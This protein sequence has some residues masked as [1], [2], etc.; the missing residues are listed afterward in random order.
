MKM[1]IFRQLIQ[2]LLFFC[3]P[4]ILSLDAQTALISDGELHTVNFNVNDKV[5]EFKIPDDLTSGRVYFEAYGGDGGRKKN[6]ADGN[7]VRAKGGQGAKI[8]AWFEIGTEAGE[9]PPGATVLFI[10]GEHGQNLNGVFARG[11]GGGG[12]TGV[13]FQE[14]NNA[15]TLLL[16]SGGGMGG[17]ADCC[18]ASKDGRP[19]EPYGCVIY[20]D[21]AY[22][23][24]SYCHY[25]QELS[26]ISLCLSGGSVL[27]DNSN[28]YGPNVV[29]TEPG[30]YVGCASCK[31]GKRG[32][33]GATSIPTNW[34]KPTGGEGGEDCDNPSLTTR[35]GFGFGGGAAGT[36]GTFY[37]SCG[38]GGGF[39]GHTDK[40]GGSYINDGIALSSFGKVRVKRGTTSD[41]KDGKVLYRI[42]PAAEAICNDVTV[43]ISGTNSV[44]VPAESLASGVLDPEFTEPL[45]FFI[46]GGY[47][48]GSS[49]LA[50]CSNLGPNLVTVTV[51]GRYSGNSTQCTSIVTVVDVTPP[52]ANCNDLTITLDNNGDYTLSNADINAISA[53]STD[54]CGIAKREV[55]PVGF[56]CFNTGPQTVILTLTDHSGTTNTCIANVNV[57]GGAPLSVN[58]QNTTVELDANGTVRLSA[59]A[60]HAGSYSDC[61][62]S[63][64]LSQSNFTCANIGD[65]TV[66]LTGTD[67][68]GVV[69]SCQARV[70]VED[71]LAP[72]ITCN[73]ETIVL[74][75]QSQIQV[76]AASLVNNASDNCGAQYRFDSRTITLELQSDIYASD[77]SWT[78]TNDQTNEV[79]AQGGDYPSWPDLAGLGD[80]LF[81][82]HT[83]RLDPGCYTLNWVDIWG[84]GFLCDY[85]I[86]GNIGEY[87][88]TP[89]FRLVDGTGNEL[90]KYTCND[91]FGHQLAVPFCV[92]DDDEVSSLNFDCLNVGSNPLALVIEDASGNAS[93]CQ[94]NVRV[95]SAPVQCSPIS[96]QLPDNGVGYVQ[97]SQLGNSPTDFCGN[98]VDYYFQTPKITLEFISDWWPNDVTW[99]I[100]DLSDNAVVA[101]GGGD[102]AIYLP[103]AR[104]VNSNRYF[105]HSFNLENGCYRLDWSDKWG[106]GFQ[107]TYQNPVPSLNL[108]SYV[109]EPIIK[110]AD[111]A[112]TVLLERFCHEV[113]GLGFS[114]EFCYD[115]GLSLQE[116]ATFDCNDIGT[117]PVEITLKYS[118]GSTSNCQTTVEVLPPSPVATCKDIEV[119]L[120]DDGEALIKIEDVYDGE[121]CGIAHLDTDILDFSCGMGTTPVTLTLTDMDGTVTSCTANV[122]VVDPE[123]PT[124]VC[125]EATVYLDENGLATVDASALDGGST[126]NCGVVA[127][128]FL[129]GSTQFSYDNCSTATAV[130]FTAT[131]K[132]ADHYGNSSTC[133]SQ[134]SVIDNTPPVL[135]CKDVI[136]PLGESGI[137]VVNQNTILAEPISDNCQIMSQDNFSIN[138]DCSQLGTHTFNLSSSDQ[139]GNESSCSATVTIV[140]ETTPTAVCQDI[141]V[142]LDVSGSAKVTTGEIDNGSSDACGSLDLSLDI[143]EFGCEQLGPNSVVLTVLDDYGNSSSCTASV[144]VQDQID[145]TARCENLTV[146]IGP[147]GQYRLSATDIDEIGSGSYDNCT[148]ASLSVSPDNFSDIGTFPL[149][150]TATDSRGNIGTCG[151]SVT[152][153]KR[154]AVLTYTGDLNVQYSDPATLSASLKDETKG[155]AIAGQTIQFT[156]GSQNVS[157]T[158]NSNG[159]ATA[160]LI[161]DQAPGNYT[162]SVGYSGNSVFEPGEDTDSFTIQAE[163]ARTTFTG[164]R[165][166]STGGSNSNDAV[167]LLAAT[168]RDITS[169]APGIDASA[170]D[171]SKATVT[172]ID[173]DTDTPISPAIPVAMLDATSGTV[174][175]D[176]EVSLDNNENAR[177]YTIGIRVDGYYISD[178]SVENAILNIYKPKNDFVVG[179]GNIILTENSGGV[180]AGDAGTANEFGFNIKFNKAG[181]NL[182]GRLRILVSRMESD[183]VLHTYQ[184]KGNNMQSLGVDGDTGYAVFTGKANIQDITDPKN[185][186]SLSG[187]KS[188]QIELYDNGNGSSD[189]IGFTLY[190]KNG[191]LW[192]SSNWDGAQTALQVLEKGKIKVHAGTDNNN[193]TAAMEENIT[194][195]QSYKEGIIQES[196]VEEV[197]QSDLLADLTAYPNPF[198]TQ[199]TVRYRLSQ[200]EQVIIEIYDLKGRRVK[201]LENAMRYEGVH[202]LT[203]YGQTDDDQYLDSGIYLISLRAGKEV[204]TRKISLVK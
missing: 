91:D 86:G 143:T 154:T 50:N 69:S 190:D 26:I 111:G 196:T 131:L 13:L 177:E 197:A 118:D 147:D 149:T 186:I 129:D 156:I 65:N 127:V 171:I 56:Y 92:S 163:D 152:V 87:N 37:S 117:N 170:G 161:M 191:E 123:F 53:G 29:T 160:S 8:G 11:A 141:S 95:Q 42:I 168:I 75:G 81:F 9:I 72:T 174:A 20:G 2:L 60:I 33:P 14:A 187:N 76:T 89:H 19:G 64:E 176:W 28:A 136:V 201:Q 45:L 145:P 115:S 30:D 178:A 110:I 144:T 167:V 166:V 179:S 63:L 25:E 164:P 16:V 200:P 172:F 4:G 7:G 32:W 203:W 84:D 17:A 44:Q 97:A 195:A 67:I 5:Q 139:S 88:I 24:N 158:T 183:N 54:N 15:Y 61:I 34:I 175:W 106:D 6:S 73:S 21:N 78:I 114:S 113:N 148:V 103:E 83:A 185:P 162:V 184:F 104:N 49:F 125:Q 198:S 58:C 193:L 47:D 70:T 27:H 120:N 189:L 133:T 194:M 18:T 52:N 23:S 102:Y 39:T 151:A 134:V 165:L 82:S 119:E 135:N 153:V 157:A 101:Q 48:E 51:A 38:A 146:E 43:D 10:I 22:E 35:G 181:T 105:S 107:C 31:T 12:G 3:L 199:T 99:T 1:A 150:L 155:T 68:N 112:G 137:V 128:T 124:A 80:A 192:F 40:G 93:T 142:Q 71:N 77:I 85:K 36:S 55:E 204:L 202:E 159:V 94:T 121:F 169:I 140:D 66:T 132:V 100:T 122:T 98:E 59:D 57:L 62:P 130:G 182:K 138:F 41:P 96:V 74:S 79:V 173:R 46:P 116:R 109:P 108:V 188:L 126:D 180:M 90:A